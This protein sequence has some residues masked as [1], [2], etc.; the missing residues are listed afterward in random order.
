VSAAGCRVPSTVVHAMKTVLTAA[1]T[2][3]IAEMTVVA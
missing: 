2:T 1:R 3:S